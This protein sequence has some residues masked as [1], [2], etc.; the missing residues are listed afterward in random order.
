MAISTDLRK[1]LMWGAVTLNLVAALLAVA[2]GFPG[3]LMR[4]ARRQEQPGTGDAD[5][6]PA[7]VLEKLRRSG[8]SALSAAERRAVIRCAT[9]AR[10]DKP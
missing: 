2:A 5:A 6:A 3:L 7:P 1:P 10:H 8:Y 4:P 9:Q